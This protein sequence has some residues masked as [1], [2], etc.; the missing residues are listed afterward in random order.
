MYIQ[1][2]D[3]CKWIRR[4]RM[5]RQ[6]VQTIKIQKWCHAEGNNWIGVTAFGDGLRRH[7]ATHCFF[8]RCLPSCFPVDNAVDIIY[9]HFLLSTVSCNSFLGVECILFTSVTIECHFLLFHIFS[10]LSTSTQFKHTLLR[11]W[12]YIHPT[13][14]V[15]V[16]F[17]WCKFSFCLMDSV[18][19]I[20][21]VL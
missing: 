17:K 10:T 15:L 6:L 3:T 13:V 16:N 21:L 2:W 18:F 1:C 9:V 19:N 8:S 7:P 4:Q 20:S 14:C 12:S 5:R 11:R